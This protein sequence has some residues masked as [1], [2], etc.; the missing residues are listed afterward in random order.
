[1]LPVNETN[2]GIL[3]DDILDCKDMLGMT[4]EE[5]GIPETVIDTKSFPVPKTY[6]D[7][8]I[9]G[10]KDYGVIY[11]SKNDS[12]E[13]DIVDS[14]WIHIKE[15]GFEQCREELVKLYGQPHDEGESPYVEADGGAV[16]WAEFRDGDTVIRLSN[17]S[18]R[19]YSELEISRRK[20]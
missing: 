14:V 15:M 17:A 11:F 12:G 16:M 4:A 3:I 18:E 19:D 1:M 20:Q 2:D 5:A 9:F 13:P 7:G 10:K 8:K 6:A